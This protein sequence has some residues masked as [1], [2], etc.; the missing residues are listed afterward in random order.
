MAKRKA[1]I[2]LKDLQSNRFLQGFPPKYVRQLRSIARMQEFPLA[3][4]LF[5][6]GTEWP[7]V[8]L[9]LSGNVKLEVNVPGRGIL[10]VQ[11]VGPGEL[12]GWSPVL[13]LG[14]MTATAR[15]RSKCRLAE[16]EASKLLAMAETELKFGVEFFRRTA[17]ALAE[18]LC[19]MRLQAWGPPPPDLLGGLPK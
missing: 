10:P 4:V 3:T 16:M 5:R 12:V 19:A 9:V 8:Y 1:M 13:G 6:Q 17:A 2:P 14:L 18:R 15:T 7:F 11:E